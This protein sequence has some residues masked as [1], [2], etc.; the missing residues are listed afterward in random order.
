MHP[1]QSSGAQ[2]PRTAIWCFTNNIPRTLGAEVVRINRA[3]CI[4]A[5]WEIRFCAHGSIDPI[6]IPQFRRKKILEAKFNRKPWEGW[7]VSSHI[8]CNDDVSRFLEA[9]FP[10]SN[11]E[12][13]ETRETE[14]HSCK[15]TAAAKCRMVLRQLSYKHTHFSL[16]FL[17]APSSSLLLLPLHYCFSLFLYFSFESPPPVSRFIRRTYQHVLRCLNPSR[18]R[19]NRTLASTSAILAIYVFA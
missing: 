18:K 3:S 1:L 7:L 13:A 16:P 6:N 11:R 10:W 9:V 15:G 12:M 4:P 8:E 14:H 17:P 19:Y 5:N 2:Y